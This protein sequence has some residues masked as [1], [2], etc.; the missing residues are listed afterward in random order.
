HRGSNF[1]GRSR[2]GE[3]LGQKRLDWRKELAPNA[4]LVA[5][6]GEPASFPR[7][8]EAA[9]RKRGW[10]VLLLEVRDANE[11]EGAFK[12]ATEARAGALLVSSGGLLTGQARRVAELALRNR[13]PDI[14][15]LRRHVE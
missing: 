5:V 6:V 13:L 1:R 2:G 3:G 11:I 12:A 14:C 8:V 7:A 4:T 15:P 10:K 9:A